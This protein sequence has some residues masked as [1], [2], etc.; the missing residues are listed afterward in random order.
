MNNT[1]TAKAGARTQTNTQAKHT[2]G[3]WRYCMFADHIPNYTIQPS[4]H[5]NKKLCLVNY[6]AG[7]PMNAQARDVTEGE[8]N[9]IA[10]APE[11][12]SE[13]KKILDTPGNGVT[14]GSHPSALA[15]I[16]R[17]ERQEVV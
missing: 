16:A 7:D 1:T 2:P 17:A 12:L 8:A 5:G 6:Y 4:P 11:L 9:L 14:P 3:P 13:L 10:A 15:A